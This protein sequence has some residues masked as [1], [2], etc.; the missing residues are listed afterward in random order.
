MP[1]LEEISQ[2]DHASDSVFTEASTEHT[3][4]HITDFPILSSPPESPPPRRSARSTQEY[5][6]CT[7]RK[8][9]HIVLLYLRWLRH[10][11]LDKPCLSH[12]CL[13]LYCKFV[14]IFHII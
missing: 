8:S 10:L 5:P 7:L 11:H 9:L 13:M 6:Q 1:Y 2:S 12:A 14:Y 3:S 4:Q